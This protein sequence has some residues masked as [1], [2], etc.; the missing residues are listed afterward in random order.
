MR[1]GLHLEA[2][3]PVLRFVPEWTRHHVQQAGEE[4]FF[5]LDRNRAGFDL[6]QIENVGDQVQQVGS[7][8]VNGAGEL[9]LLAAS[10]CHP[11]C[12]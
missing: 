3:A 4:D 11:D 8:A 2:E 12:R 6:R 10:G 7:G 1:I 5:R 9:D